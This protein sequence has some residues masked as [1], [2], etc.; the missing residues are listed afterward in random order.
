MDQPGQKRFQMCFMMATSFHFSTL[1]EPK[2]LTLFGRQTASHAT[3]APV[4]I[5]SDPFYNKLLN[6]LSMSLSGFGLQV[7]VGVL[8]LWGSHVYKCVIS[9]K[10]E[11][12][13]NKKNIECVWVFWHVS[14][15]F[16]PFLL[17]IFSL[18]IILFTLLFIDCGRIQFSF[19]LTS[20]QS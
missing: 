13:I 6:F 17:D 4:A 14:L 2:P 15:F 12:L 3:F 5:P 1:F 19:L 7:K 16:S 20:L 8:V 11:E 18:F 10:Q 9:L